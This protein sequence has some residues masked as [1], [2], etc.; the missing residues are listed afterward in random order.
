[1][2]TELQAHCKNIVALHGLLR[3]PLTMP[4]HASTYHAM[5]LCVGQKS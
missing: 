3:T 1:M 2:H 5:Q 4:G